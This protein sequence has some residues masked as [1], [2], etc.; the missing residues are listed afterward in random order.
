MKSGAGVQT[1]NSLVGHTSFR[2]HFGRREG[3]LVF[4][5]LSLL[6]PG[7]LPG[8]LRAGDRCH[9][10]TE[11]ILLSRRR[12]KHNRNRTRMLMSSKW[13]SGCARSTPIYPW[14]RWCGGWANLFDLPRAGPPRAAGF[15]SRS[16]GLSCLGENEIGNTVIIQQSSRDIDLAVLRSLIH[17]H[18]IQFAQGLLFSRLNLSTLFLRACPAS[19][20]ILSSSTAR[21]QRANPVWSD[22][23]ARARR[24]PRVVRLTHGPH[25]AYAE[26]TT[27][28]QCTH[29]AAES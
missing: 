7:S 21:N 9:P 23:V 10:P 2:T 4:I 13:P 6:P 12:K 1:P 26:P 8:S 15:R 24:T 22:Q 16:R 3:G 11:G 14:P 29:V 17:P 18:R 28:K 19:R 25:T 5:P 20:R 27:G